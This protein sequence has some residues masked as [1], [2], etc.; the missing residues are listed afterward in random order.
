MENIWTPTMKPIPNYDGYFCDED[1]NFIS[2]IKVK[3]GKLLKPS[4]Q[5]SGYFILGVTQ[6]GKQYQRRV[7]RLVAI[8]HLPNP[9]NLPIVD[10]KDRDITNN[11]IKNLRWATPSENTLNVSEKKVY[12]ELEYSN[13]DLNNEIWVKSD[14]LNGY[15]VYK[16]EVSSLGRIKYVTKQHRNI[17]ITPKIKE[18]YN[19]LSFR[20][21]DPNLK[22]LRT[23]THV[24]VWKVFNGEYDSSKYVVNHKDGVKHNCRLDNLELCTFS[25]NTKHAHE[26]GMINVFRAMTK[27]IGENIIKDFYEHKISPYQITIKY[28]KSSNHIWPLL[29]GEYENYEY[30][31][32]EMELCKT[33]KKTQ[34]VIISIT[35]KKS[36]VT[37]IKDINV[38]KEIIELSKQGVSVRGIANKI[39]T[40]GS[41][42][43][44][45]YVT[46]DFQKL[47]EEYPKLFI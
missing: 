47:R 39:G 16:L 45:K 11:S 37:K 25:E 21:E 42:A 7:H 23:L 28:G 15:G 3:K 32:E 22:R 24:F 35:N 27:E 31:N 18:T 10:H 36:S 43:V 13:E 8:T 4:K 2:T 14:I 46:N 5:H 38:F 26:N 9:N 20:P 19:T 17:L 34:G 44:H 12:S 29:R 33:F 40:I 6:N 1:A 30:S 41:S